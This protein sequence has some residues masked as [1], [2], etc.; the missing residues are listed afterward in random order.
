MEKILV[1]W[2]AAIAVTLIFSMSWM[3]VVPDILD[4]TLHELAQ[5]AAVS[6][7]VG[8]KV[9]FISARM[10]AYALIMLGPIAVAVASFGAAIASTRALFR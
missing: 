4:R 9:T 7:T 6:P 5:E 10:G 8:N 1:P 2:L 3:N